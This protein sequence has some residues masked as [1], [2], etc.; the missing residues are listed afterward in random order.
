MRVRADLPLA[1]HTLVRHEEILDR[2]L[3]A[4]HVCPPCAADVL[5]QRGQRRRF[6]AVARSSDQNE[7]VAQLR[8]ALH[9]R[10]VAQFANLRDLR[11]D[12]AKRGLDAAQHVARIATESAQ[13]LHLNGKIQ[14]PLPLQ[15]RAL[16]FL[17][18]LKN[19]LSHI[20]HVQHI[21]DHRLQH[22]ID[23]AH[24]RTAHAEMQVGATPMND[25]EKI[26]DEVVRA[27]GKK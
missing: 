16:V 2:V 15:L 1:D 5:R 12:V 25:H 26:L 14:L 20:R 18:H 10:P 7:P 11:R 8:E 21:I 3:D 24:R 9:R 4:D 23:A 17:Q 6:A 27:H 13:I 19:Q 22:A